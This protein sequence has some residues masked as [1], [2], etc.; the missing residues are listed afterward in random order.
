MSRK[1]V[2]MLMENSA[3][4]VRNVADLLAG[5]TRAVKMKKKRSGSKNGLLRGCRQD[6]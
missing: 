3:G 4:F 6:C 5:S 1:T 2:F